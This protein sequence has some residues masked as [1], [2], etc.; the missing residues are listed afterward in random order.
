MGA[1]FELHNDVEERHVG[2]PLLLLIQLPEIALQDPLVVLLLQGAHLHAE[3][4]LVLGR[5]AAFHI[6]DHPSQQVGTQL[7]VQS[8]HLCT[9]WS[10]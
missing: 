1:L 3:D 2:G 5:Q 10:E 7:L 6:F 8:R 9:D 4:A